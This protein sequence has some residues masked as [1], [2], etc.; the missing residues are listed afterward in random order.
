[1]SSATKAVKS[2]FS[3]RFKVRLKLR[4]PKGIRLSQGD[5]IIGGKK[6]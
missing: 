4:A 1:M 6:S 5:A 3:D 2:K